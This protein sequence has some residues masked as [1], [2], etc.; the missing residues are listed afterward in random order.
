MQHGVL[1]RWYLKLHKLRATA[2]Y[3]RIV[4]Q[5]SLNHAF[6]GT[7]KRRSLILLC[8]AIN[9]SVVLL[10][11]A[12]VI[13]MILL[14]TVFGMLL[15]LF[16]LGLAYV[17]RPRYGTLPT[18]AYGR[19]DLPHLFRLV[20]EVAK[21]IGSPPVSAIVLNEDYNASV[22]NVGREKHQ[23]LTLGIPYF[24][25][26]KPQARVALIAH[27]LG[28]FAS[29]DPNK[30]DTVWQTLGILDFWTS[31]FRQDAHEFTWSPIGLFTNAVSLVLSL[32]PASLRAFILRMTYDDSQRSEYLA[33]YRSSLVAGKNAVLESSDFLKYSVSLKEFLTHSFGAVD[34]EGRTNVE[35]FRDL[36]WRIPADENERLTRCNL[37][38]S[39]QID[40]THPP[41][42]LRQNFVAQLPELP[43][44]VTLSEAASAEIDQELLPVFEMI[45]EQLIGQ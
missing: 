35:K 43:L 32:I 4:R 22:Q 6:A 34:V 33:D 2:L 10:A 19:E 29:D 26:L 8:M 7:M 30:G 23:L 20:D 13:V 3:V 15:G 9:L 25:V 37:L 27:E 17:Q 40:T 12:G 14:K 41:M 18:N 42:S 45:S 16:L 36:V 24:Y 39:S 21:A 38:P 44:Q 5:Q 31:T 28:H 1:G 11:L